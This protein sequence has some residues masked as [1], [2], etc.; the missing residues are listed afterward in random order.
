MVVF[1]PPSTCGM[2]TFEG[3]VDVQDILKSVNLSQNGQAPDIDIDTI[4]K[5]STPS[6]EL[7]EGVTKEI[8]TA[9]PPENNAKPEIG[10]AVQ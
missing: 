6:L 1:R 7:P 8:V 4:L 5:N 10:D 9:A 2:S 3:V